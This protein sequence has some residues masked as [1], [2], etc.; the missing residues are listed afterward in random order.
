MKKLLLLPFLSLAA[1]GQMTMQLAPLQ[2]RSPESTVLKVLGP[3]T[4]K[5]APKESAASGYLM[6]DWSYPG[7][8]LS[9]AKDT[10]S[11]HVEGFRLKAPCKLRT[12]EG[13][14][15]GSSESELTRA[16][17]QAKKSGSVYSWLD[18]KAYQMNMLTVKAGKVVEIASFPGPE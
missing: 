8:Q 1:W 12:K 17:P 11:F 4:S 15:I 14:G 16:Y 13:I 7:L 9:M 3:P 18:E 6:S 5:T 10:G 2:P